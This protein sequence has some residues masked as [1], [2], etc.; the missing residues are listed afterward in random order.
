MRKIKSGSKKIGIRTIRLHFSLQILH[1]AVH[2]QLD[3]F[4]RKAHSSPLLPG[5]VEAFFDGSH[6]NIF[7]D[8]AVQLN[9]QPAKLLQLEVE[10]PREIVS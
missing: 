2:E 5:S 4:R 1:P 10:R 7:A 8:E 3:L 9:L 6:P